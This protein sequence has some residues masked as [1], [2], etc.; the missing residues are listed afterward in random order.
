MSPRRIDRSPD[1]RHLRDDGY[2][3]RIRAGYLVM[4]GVPYV[5][6][7]GGIG[8]GILVDQL[9]LATDETTSGP[10]D[11][12]M[13]WAGETPCDRTGQPLGLFRDSPDAVTIDAELTTTHR[14]SAKPATP[15]SDYYV[16]FTRYVRLITAHA[17]AIDPTVTAATFP[18]IESDDEDS[19]FAYTDTASSRANITALND[20]LCAHRI[21]IVGVGGTGSYIMDYVAKTE[22]K[23]IHL[24]DGDTFFLHNAY[25]SP[26]VPT[27]EQLDAKPLK[28]AYHQERYSGFR[29]GIVAHPVYI[30]A[31]NLDE[32]KSMTFVF[33]ALDR[34][35]P[36]R[37]IIE[38][39]EELGIPFID[40]GMDIF[41]ADGA[42][43][44]VL[45]VTTSTPSQ[46]DHVREKHRISLADRNDNDDYAQNI[47][48]VELNA[49]NAAMAVIKWKKLIGYYH[50][51]EHEQHSMYTLESNHLLNEDCA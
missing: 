44:G 3:I 13:R 39:L 51:A 29:R 9:Q 14:F 40:V 17:E 2:D 12:T 28:V 24:F 45:R 43:E 47:Q 4:S 30:T 31:A 37:A 16:K 35:T 18:A 41:R 25:R 33:L 11:H 32:L 21:A 19:V 36:K 49:F 6:A 10:A 1:L 7:G 26:G 46:R 50:D 15:D 27:R 48:I 42:L 23:E 20:K 38:R 5:A 8:R 34:G 22:V